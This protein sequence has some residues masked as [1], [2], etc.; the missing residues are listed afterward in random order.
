MT[1]AEASDPLVIAERG[2]LELAASG[3][4]AGYATDLDLDGADRVF[5]LAVGKA[6]AAA[7][8]GLLK[9]LP[10]VHGAV[11]V[12]HLGPQGHAEDHPAVTHMRGDH[13]VPGE[14]SARA[15]RELRAVVA[16]WRLTA[17]DVVVVSVSGGT[18]ALVAA[19][20][21]PLTPADLG[22]VSAAL[23]GSGVDAA[24]ANTVRRRLGQLHDGGLTRV[25]RPAT[26]LTAVVSDNAQEVAASVGSGPTI[27]DARPVST[28]A[29]DA[30][31]AGL[32]SRVL[33]ALTRGRPAG[34]DT[35]G[36]V[37]LAGMRDYTAACARA[38]RR[39][40]YATDV[41]APVVHGAWDQFAARL[42]RD[43]LESRPGGARAVLGCGEVEVAVRAGGTGGRCQQVALAVALAAPQD[44]SFRF[45]AFA[46]DG[47]DHLEGVRGAVVDSRV[48]ARLRS[49]G[50]QAALAATDANGL[51]DRHGCLVKGPATGENLGDA[52]VLCLTPGGWT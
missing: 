22:R 4:H 5:T 24:E 9:A 43:A 44:V 14:R 34:D 18:S 49:D 8:S 32:R 2:L 50:G 28:T 46:S 20:V 16:G 48:A 35:D 40:G 13:P 25:L 19:P 52:Y 26:V 38:A 29:V 47:R 23:L 41:V 31:P 39:L 45:A 36:L 21:P 15:A 10:R 30:L 42:W 11:V 33:T 12:D 1:G 51:L 3:L 6:A 7:T 37:V 27:A 17:R